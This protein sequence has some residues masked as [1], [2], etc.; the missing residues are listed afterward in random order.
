[1]K[2][3]DGVGIRIVAKIVKKVLIMRAKV[4]KSVDVRRLKIVA[5]LSKCETL[6]KAMES[7]AFIQNSE[8]T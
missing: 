1:M 8:S 5:I 4:A 6:A 3:V 7:S 2:S